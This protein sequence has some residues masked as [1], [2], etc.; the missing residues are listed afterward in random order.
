M[1]IEESVRSRDLSGPAGW[2]AKGMLIALPLA[3][4]FFLFNAP[5][6]VGWLVFNEQYL[7]LFLGLALCAT[8]VLIPA[9]WW[10]KAQRIH[11]YD[12]IMSLAGLG[13]GLIGY[14]FRPVGAVKRLLFTLA[15][16]GLLI[17]VVHSGPYAAS[18][19]ATNGIGLLLA[20]ILVGVEWLARA[21]RIAA[22]AAAVGSDG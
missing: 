2:L 19:W 20:V 8:F 14:L 12:W 18:T 22:S 11:W 9:G 6:W 17:P 3:G 15:A 4:I 1:E 21:L 5:Q 7:G 13:V 10:D 16:I